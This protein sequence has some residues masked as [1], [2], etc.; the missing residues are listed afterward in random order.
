MKLYREVKA[1][2]RLPD[3][4]G[5][6]FT[7]MGELMYDADRKEWFD[8]S[9]TFPVKWWLEPIEIIEEEW[10]NNIMK[11]VSFK[12]DEN[13]QAATYYINATITTILSKL[14]GDD[15]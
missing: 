4:N 8:L 2:E 10:G 14:K 6:Y 12:S 7:N 9:D 15:I 11:E 1:S 5:D 13:W 3:E